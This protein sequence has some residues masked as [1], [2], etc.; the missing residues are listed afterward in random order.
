[1]SIYKYITFTFIK[2]VLYIFS[3]EKHCSIVKA[4]DGVRIMNELLVDYSVNH[5]SDNL[6]KILHSFSL[7]VIIQYIMNI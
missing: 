5:S 7:T 3:A 2:F 4:E 1:M 6:S